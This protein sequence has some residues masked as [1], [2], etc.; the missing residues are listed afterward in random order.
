[1]YQAARRRDTT[2][3]PATVYRTLAWLADAGL[4]GSRHLEPH[5]DRC[6][7][8]EPTRRSEHH[9]F[10]CTQCGRAIEFAAPAIERTKHEFARRYDVRIDTAS[11]TLHGVCRACR[12]EGAVDEDDRPR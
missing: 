10:V 8:Y 7:H 2:L 5:G 9:H 1:V 11:L 3:N 12:T 6:E 4:V